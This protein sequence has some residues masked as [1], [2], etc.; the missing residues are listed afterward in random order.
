MSVQRFASHPAISNTSPLSPQC[1]ATSRFHTSP[2]HTSLLHTSLFHA[3]KLRV[4]KIAC[5]L[6]LFCLFCAAVVASPAQTFHTLVTFTGPNGANPS[7]LVQGE[8]GN[9][10]GATSGLG[11]TVCG[12]L[13]TSTVT[14]VLTTLHTFVCSDGT[15]PD[16][17]TLGSDGNFYGTTLFGGTNNIGVAFRL[18]PA[19]VFSVLYNFDESGG[20][21]GNPTGVTQGSDGN[22]YGTTQDGGTLGYGT[23]F[24]MT[25]HG[26]LTT[27]YNFDST[28]GA[29]PFARPIQGPDGNFYG[30]TGGGGAYGGGVVYKLTPGGVITVL[31][32]FGQTSTDGYSL[33]CVLA[34]ALDGNFYGVTL[35]GGTDGDGTVFKVT[36]GGVFTNLLNFDG[37]DGDFPGSVIQATDGLLY[38]PSVEGGANGAGDLYSMTTAGVQTILHSFNGHDGDGPLH[39]IQH[40]NGTIYG[41]TSSSINYGSI[42]SLGVGVGPFVK[43]VTTVGAPGAS[44]TILGTGLT[45][46]TAVAFNG[47]AAAFTVVSNSSITTTVPVGATTGTV[48][49]TT[50]GGTL[51]SNVPFRVD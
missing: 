15:F 26:A 9:L 45:G 46:S 20:G 36:P 29:A 32:S 34:L 13:F 5:A 21:G 40:T 14:G 23:V 12:T 44:V 42:Y 39:M 19:G 51:S 37:T 17:L 27:V 38:G 4:R 10:W 18:T 6:F 3:G 28:N 43:T 1:P 50:P 33:D 2:S 48:T 11:G 47:T 16:G 35:Y 49:V 41:L 30:T 31:H 25:P 7:T 8:N 22:F 24:R